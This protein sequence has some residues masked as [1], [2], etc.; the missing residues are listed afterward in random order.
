MY[1]CMHACMCVCVCVCLPACLAASPPAW[2]PG[3]LAAWLAGRPSVCLCTETHT[4]RSTY[5]YQRATA[6]TVQKAQEH[7][8][9]VHAGDGALVEENWPLL[10]RRKQGRI[11]HSFTLKTNVMDFDFEGRKP[12]EPRWRRA[13]EPGALRSFAKSPRKAKGHQEAARLQPLHRF[14]WPFGPQRSAE[15]LMRPCGLRLCTGPGCVSQAPRANPTGPAYRLVVRLSQVGAHLLP[16][17]GNRP[18]LIQNCPG[19]CSGKHGNR[20]SAE[21]LVDDALLPLRAEHGGNFPVAEGQNVQ[22]LSRRLQDASIH[23]ACQAEWCCRPAWCH[24]SRIWH[25][26][27]L[28]S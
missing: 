20:P 25:D 10:N 21:S 15:S 16:N 23:S 28:R 27:E 8:S 1:V 5:V 9:P 2:L 13:R 19:L 7:R 26:T 24:S 18:P 14:K 11:L 12:C 6:K 22:N 17:D 3:C 4:C